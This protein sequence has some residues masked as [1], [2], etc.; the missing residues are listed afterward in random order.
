MAEPQAFSG[1]EGFASRRYLGKP[2]N[3]SQMQVYTIERAK[4]ST[5]KKP[6]EYR[7]SA[8]SDEAEG[9][10]ET[11]QVDAKDYIDA[12]TSEVRAQNDARFAEVLARLD[13][14]NPA[15]WWQN[16]LLGFGFLGILLAILAFGGDQFSIG[17]SLSP[18][19]DRI[20]GERD[21]AIASA[22]NEIKGD[23]AVIFSDFR[24]DQAEV[25]ASQDAKLDLIL[26]QLEGISRSLE[27]AARPEQ[28]E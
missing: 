26:Q 6:Q 17:V 5:P 20:S 15:T 24:R 9:A 25:D 28:V 10:R 21:A 7:T 1:G 12:K 3:K 8:L 23:Q 22:I 27:G 13:G 19:L 4:G 18:E 16:A 14:M 2:W 11:M